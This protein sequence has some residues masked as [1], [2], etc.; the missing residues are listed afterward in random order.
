MAL[1]ESGARSRSF[2]LPPARSR[3]ATRGRSP[4]SPRGPNGRRPS[5]TRARERRGGRL[6]PAVGARGR[7][8]LRVGLG[9]RRRG[10]RP[11]ASVRER[12]GHPR[13]RGDRLGGARAVRAARQADRDPPGQGS[14]IFARPVA[15]G[16]TEVGGRV[17]ARR[18]ARVPPQRRS[19]PGQ[20]GSP[21][22]IG[23]QGRSGL[24]GA[25]QRCRWIV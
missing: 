5:S 23:V 24:N 19:G 15:D 2:A 4:G 11:G 18:G 16:Y 22:R 6:S 8:G 3:S 9:G 10:P 17:V 25:G 13:G 21:C 1:R 20:D 12:R 7:L 14:E